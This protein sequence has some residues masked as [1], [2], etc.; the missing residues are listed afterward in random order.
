M[1]KLFYQEIVIIYSIDQ[2]SETNL[3][4][5]NFVLFQVRKLEIIQLKYQ[6]LQLENEQLNNDFGKNLIV[7]SRLEGLCRDLQKQNRQIKVR[8]VTS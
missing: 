6:Q 1:Q 7:R 5:N 8:L 3:V 4:I 2:Q